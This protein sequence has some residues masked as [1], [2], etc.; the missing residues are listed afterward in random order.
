VA[1]ATGI[2]AGTRVLDVGC[3]S[4]ELL[5]LAAGRG[6][7]VSGLDAAEG[8]DRDRLPA[9]DLHVGPME[10]LP[11]DDDTFDV[12]TGF[13]AFQFAADMVVALREAARV[14]R[15]GGLVAVCNWSPP[16][17]PLPVGDVRNRFRYVV[18]RVRA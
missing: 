16:A 15:G 4:G 1:D 7:V 9:A 8:H 10:R 11:G 12:V 13:N 5:S 14:A 6:G 17:G 3:G 18:A 2:G